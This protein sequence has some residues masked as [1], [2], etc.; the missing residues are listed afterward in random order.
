M[1]NNLDIQQ[2]ITDAIVRVEILSQRFTRDGS[3]WVIDEIENVTLHTSLYNPIGGSS[4]IATPSWLA[5][6]KAVVNIQNKDEKC[7]LYCVLAA[8]HPQKYNAY[9][10]CLN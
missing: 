5:D 3:G 6:K 9:R 10:S 2:Q 1:L 4:F 7:F 8:S